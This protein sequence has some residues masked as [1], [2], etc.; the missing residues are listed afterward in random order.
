MAKIPEFVMHSYRYTQ[1]QSESAPAKQKAAAQAEDAQAGNQT[2]DKIPDISVNPP[3]TQA[4][5]DAR[6]PVPAS[7]KTQVTQR[8]IAAAI[9]NLPGETAPSAP[10]VPHAPAPA[11]ASAVPQGSR[12]EQVIAE[13]IRR[14]ML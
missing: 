12:K 1:R 4:P 14:K 5:A 7:Q 10:A 9:H 2:A 13:V 8:V 6:T 3:F 11:Q